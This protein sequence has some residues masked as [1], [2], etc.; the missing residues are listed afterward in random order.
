MTKHE[1]MNE[2]QMTDELSFASSD[3]GI[4]RLRQILPKNPRD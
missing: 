4:N 3:F 2:V 1:T